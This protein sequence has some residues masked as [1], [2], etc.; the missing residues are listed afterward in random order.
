VIALKNPLS[1]RSQRTWSLDWIALIDFKSVY[2]RVIYRF[3]TGVNYSFRT[4][5]IIIVDQPGD[6]YAWVPIGIGEGL[7]V[8]ALQPHQ[9]Y[10]SVPT[11]E[12][13]MKR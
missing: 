7:T 6:A 2:L 10:G 1:A 4:A 11:S 9:A 5:K 8:F 12:R 3:L 13:A